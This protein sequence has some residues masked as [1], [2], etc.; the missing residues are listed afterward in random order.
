MKYLVRKDQ[1]NREIIG[2][3]LNP[4]V[5]VSPSVTSVDPESLLVPVADWPHFVRRAQVIMDC[6]AFHPERVVDKEG[7]LE[8]QYLYSDGEMDED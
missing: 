2:I 8:R 4:T 3:E 5:N 6:R 1:G 7:R